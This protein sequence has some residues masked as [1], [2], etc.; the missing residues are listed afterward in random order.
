MPVTLK[1]KQ[2]INPDIISVCTQ[3]LQ[4]CWWAAFSA[5]PAGFLIA[6]YR[7]ADSVQHVYR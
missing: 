7:D 5:V 6:R 4:F 2:R 3:Q 1:V